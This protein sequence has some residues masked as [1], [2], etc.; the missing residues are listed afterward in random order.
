MTEAVDTKHQ[1]NPITE[2]DKVFETGMVPY[3]DAVTHAQGLDGVGQ[4]LKV[5]GVILG[6]SGLGAGFYIYH[7]PGFG[8][9]LG[10]IVAFLGIMAGGALYGF[11][12]LLAAVGQVLLALIDTA[13]GTKI[14]ATK[15]LQGD[16]A[17]SS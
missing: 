13:I 16:T 12:F 6:I 9:Q 7:S 3:K 11:G 8:S 10:V 1:T 14:V 2:I 15:S 17:T 5:V 4:F